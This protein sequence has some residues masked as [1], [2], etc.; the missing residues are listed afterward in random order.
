VRAYTGIG[1]RK[2]PFNILRD[3]EWYARAFAGEGYTLRSGGAVGADSAFY[4]GC[5]KG[6]GLSEVWSPKDEHVPEHDWA[7]HFVRQCCWEHPLDSMKP[8]VQTLLIRNMYQV[9][10]EDGNTP[11]EFLIYWSLGDPMQ[12][13]F[14]SGGTRYAVRAAHYVGIPTYN[15]RNTAKLLKNLLREPYE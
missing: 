7:R 4:R 14:D 3:M 5:V 9:L 12:K 8:F 1:S 6:G 2:T 11:S 15:L 13:G 10:G